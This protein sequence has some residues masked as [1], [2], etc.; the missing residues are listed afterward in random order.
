L[1]SWQGTGISVVRSIW[2]NLSATSNKTDWFSSDRDRGRPGEH[3]QAGNAMREEALVFW[4][5]PFDRRAVSN[6][7]FPSVSR[8]ELFYL[9]SANCGKRLAS[10]KG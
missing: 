10:V 5:P 2:A 7:S 4:T 6:N 1:S 3:R 8:P 9:R